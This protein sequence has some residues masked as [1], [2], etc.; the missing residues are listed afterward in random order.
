MED[1]TCP[2]CGG[3]QSE[4]RCEICGR[5]TV[6]ILQQH[7]AVMTKRYPHRYQEPKQNVQKSAQNHIDNPYL[8]SIHDKRRQWKQKEQRTRGAMQS[9]QTMRILNFISMAV[10][11]FLLLFI[12]M[13]AFY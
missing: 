9:N 7:S 12:I 10:F 6:K 3:V 11:F 8:K 4:S 2:F 5:P 1:R 13:I